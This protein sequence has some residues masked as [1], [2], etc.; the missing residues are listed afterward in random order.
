V[1]RSKIL[2]IFFLLKP[3][4]KLFAQSLIS[5]QCREYLMPR[6]RFISNDLVEFGVLDKTKFS[7]PNILLI[8]LKAV[9]ISLLRSISNP[10]RS[11]IVLFHILVV[12]VPVVQ[13][14][15]DAFYV[16]NASED[17]LDFTLRRFR[18]LHWLLGK[19]VLIILV[20]L[21]GCRLASLSPGK[22]DGRCLTEFQ[23]RCLWSLLVNYAKILVC[24]L[25]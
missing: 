24:G 2:V 6:I 1:T 10:T 18:R 16:R 7:L 11:T 9:H 3:F 13:V 20:L 21:S 5:D 4:K 17:N 22:A 25:F 12:H 23:Q 8:N 14:H 19:G 15:V